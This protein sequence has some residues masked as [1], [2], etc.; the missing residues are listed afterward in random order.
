MTEVQTKKKQPDEAWV[1]KTPEKIPTFDVGREKETFIE[2][3]KDFA[4]LST[5]VAPA[6]QHQQQLQS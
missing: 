1:R 5:S 3:R 6:Q 4:D 2:A